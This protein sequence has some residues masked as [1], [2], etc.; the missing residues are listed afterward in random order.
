MNVRPHVGPHPQR[1]R[2]LCPLF[3]GL[4]GSKMSLAIVLLQLWMPM[5]LFAGTNVFA[6]TVSYLYGDA[7][8]VSPL[9]SYQYFEWPG[10]DVLHLDSSPRVSYFYPFVGGS[11]GVSAV[12]S[13]VV[14]S[15]SSLP[16]DGQTAATVT[17]TLLDENGNPLSGKTVRIRVAEQTAGGVV[18]LS[19]VTQPAGATDGYGHATATLRSAVAGTAIISVEDVTDGVVLIRQP[20]V[21]FG[22]GLVVPGAALADAVVQMANSSSNLLTHSI[23][24]IATEEGRYGDYFQTQMTAD[25]RAQGVNALAA[26]VGTVFSL[27]PLLKASGEALEAG[28]ASLWWEVAKDLGQDFAP[29]ALSLILDTIAGSSTGLT[30]VGQKIDGNNASLQAAELQAG[31]QLV[32]GVPP[33]TAS[34]VAAY[35]NDLAL[36]AQANNELRLVLLAQR[37]LLL[38]LQQNSVV[39]QAETDLL[40]AVFK[41]INVVVV[42]AGT[43]VTLSPIGGKLAMAGLGVAEG[44]DA[45]AMNQQNLN[46]DQQGYNTAVMSLANCYYLSSL[47]DGNTRAGFNQ[48]A[49]GQVPSPITGAIVSVDSVKTYKPLPG[50]IGDLSHW[51]RETFG[52]TEYVHV[53]KAY[54]LLTLRNTSSR[55]AVF[56]VNAFYSHT[57]ALSDALGIH[58]VTIVL[59]MVASAVTNIGAGQSVAVR[60]DYFD[61]ATGATP[62]DGSPIRL[63]VLGS[64]GGGGLFAVDQT[65]STIRWQQ[66]GV[67]GW[68]TGASPMGGPQPKDD[69]GS[70]NVFGLETPI[71]AFVCP[72]P[73]NQIYQGQVW[74]VNPFAIPLLA[75]VAQPVPP[76]ATVVSTDGSV[77]GGWIVWTDTI[78]TNGVV[79]H[80]FSF[81]LSVPPGTET[82]APPPTVI[83]SDG[84]GTNSLTM[85][86]VAAGFSGL[87]PVGVSG[88]V[89]TGAWGVDTAA[90]LMVTNFTAAA[91]AGSLAIS[92]TDTN[93]TVVTNLSLSVSVGGWTSVS[94]DYTLP[95][96]LAPGSY[97]VR[98]ILSMGGGGGQVFSGTYVLGAAPVWFGWGPGTGVLVD[99]F[100]LELQGTT[101]YGYL[102]QASTNLV[103]WQPAQYLVLTNGSGYFT[104][105]YAPYYGQ[106]F[107]RAVAASQGQ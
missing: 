68:I 86:A 82:N 91:Q 65:S 49:Q 96:T 22:S 107:Y 27:L 41:D 80:F 30:R 6:P 45:Y 36:R 83:F 81:A 61:G 54:S 73:T 31:R 84:S 62:D 64:D 26:G 11:T 71:K 89:P 85:T 77:G 16:A 33:G 24:G 87:F 4:S 8:A 5:E 21:R 39:G 34:Y 97:A 79:E 38:D 12:F 17:V 95:G 48:I 37:G 60:V 9:V 92:L 19:S 3:G 29:D 94:L 23:A 25:K 51:T 10:N 2:S 88:F 35:Q 93:G 15:P 105:Y 106:R 18:A 44:L 7:V 32:A 75:T 20:T 90:Q 74:V 40:G 99:G 50:I 100:A 72:N 52:V 66:A 69:G 103:D 101:G 14:V 57:F 76:G 42:A 13:Q 63:Q 59:P 102:I 78:A 43:I 67:G 53:D 98:G 56:N 1:R 70:T 55:A 58:G 104:D 28:A 46:D 47:I